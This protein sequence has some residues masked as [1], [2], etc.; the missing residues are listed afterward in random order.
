MEPPRLPKTSDHAKRKAELEETHKTDPVE[1]P[2]TPEEIKEC[3]S[4]FK[5]F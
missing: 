1:P 2:M 5:D 4:V 3:E